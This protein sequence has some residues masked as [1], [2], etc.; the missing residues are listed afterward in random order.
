MT[1]PCD[2]KMPVELT[3]P[4][5]RDKFIE[6]VCEWSDGYTITMEI[7]RDALYE[8]KLIQQREM[9]QIAIPMVI[10]SD[11]AKIKYVEMISKH[12]SHVTRQMELDAINAA[13]TIQQREKENNA[14]VDRTGVSRF[15]EEESV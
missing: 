1:T 3:S 14:K 5:A 11:R 2:F 6:M 13:I 8:A 12:T 9:K 7:M 15:C 10:H 4:Y